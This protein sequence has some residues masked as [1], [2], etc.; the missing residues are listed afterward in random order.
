M[1]SNAF[2]P[3]QGTFTH[4]AS[5]TCHLVDGFQPFFYNS[6]LIPHLT[7]LE[8]S[9][10]RCE[11]GDSQF[12]RLTDRE[13]Y[14]E[15]QKLDVV[16]CRYIHLFLG[17]ITMTMSPGCINLLEE[18]AHSEMIS[19]G[20]STKELHLNTG[21]LRRALSAALNFLNCFEV[22]F[23]NDD[24]TACSFSCRLRSCFQRFHG[25]QICGF[26]FHIRRR[27][28]SIPTLFS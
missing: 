6:G 5:E 26:L 14:V 12:K 18:V 9:T 2:V 11:P 28:V 20:S 16:D 24:G 4:L 13:A 23:L 7:R 17:T 8:E 22:L 1:C 10:N 27:Q 21:F 19:V 25:A 3:G 15:L